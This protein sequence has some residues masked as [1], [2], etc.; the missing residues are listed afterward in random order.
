LKSGFSPSSPTLARIALPRSS[1]E[2]PVWSWK[3]M[4]DWISGVVRTPPKSE[5]T[6]SIRSAMVKHSRV[7]HSA[8][9]TS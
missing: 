8:Q 4:N 9:T 5:I 3:A 7:A 2:I 6:A 1:G